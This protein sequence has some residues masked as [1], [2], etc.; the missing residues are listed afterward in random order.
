MKLSRIFPLAVA[1]SFFCCL[2][3]YAAPKTYQVTGPVLELTDKTIVIQKGDE[4]W[5]I[6]RDEST[7]H[8]GVVKVGEKVTVYYRMTATSIES[9]LGNGE[10]PASEKAKSKKAQ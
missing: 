2:S 4:R 5:E 6:A 7:K 3:A 8:L 1:L 10:K 9:K